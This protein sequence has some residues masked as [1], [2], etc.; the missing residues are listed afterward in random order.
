M[1]TSYENAIHN[2]HP[3]PTCM[4]RC[5]AKYDAECCYQCGVSDNS[6][7]SLILAI[8]EYIKYT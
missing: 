7:M 2:I 5:H 8:Y 1:C 6:F 4:K 3:D